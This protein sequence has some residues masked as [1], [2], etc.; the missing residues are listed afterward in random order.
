MGNEIDF[1]LEDGIDLHI[2]SGPGIIN[3]PFDHVTVC[4][5]AIDA[6]MKGVVLKDQHC[7]TANLIYLL[8]NYIIKNKNFKI[9]GGLA[10]NNASGGLNPCVVDAAI[11]YGVSVIW[12]PTLSAANHKMG[13]SA[14]SAEKQAAM[15]K[16]KTKLWKD[17]PISVLDENG[18]LL[19]EVKDIIHLIADADVVLGTGH[20]SKN[21]VELVIKEA[22]EANAKKILIN[23]PEHLIGMDIDDMNR[24]AKNG[25]YIEHSYSIYFSKKLTNEYMYEMITKVESDATVVVSDLGQMGRPN[26]VAGL[27][28]FI[29]N[30]LK[31]GL[32]KKIIK[33]VLCEN[34][35][36]LLN[37]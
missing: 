12:M 8:D 5:E 34:P 19:P 18:K 25:I 23:H 24:H 1:I 21:E 22:K 7:T 2:H 37:I 33:K 10:L 28:I 27:K 36:R 30:M 13:H 14:M 4:K 20:L 3:R 16:P 11:K 31:L 9:M 35:A 26:P 6:K 17:P 15:P 32:D 29:E